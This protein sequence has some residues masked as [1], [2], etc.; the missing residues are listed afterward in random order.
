MKMKK[1]KDTF[2]IKKEALKMIMPVIAII[3]VLLSKDKTPEALLFLIGVFA[4]I[5]IGKNQFAKK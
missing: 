5:L 4:G 1:S 2:T 3:A